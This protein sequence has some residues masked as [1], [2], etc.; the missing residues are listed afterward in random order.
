MEEKSAIKNIKRIFFFAILGIMIVGIALVM[1]TKNDSGEWEEIWEIPGEGD[2][3]RIAAGNDCFYILGNGSDPYAPPE[4]Q[5]FLCKFDL[6]G[7]NE[8]AKKLDIPMIS[9]PYWHDAI[10]T[11][12]S[13][14]FV[15][16][17]NY[18]AKYYANGSLAWS[19]NI[20]WAT[21]EAIAVNDSHVFIT[22]LTRYLGSPFLNLM[23]YDA[24]GSLDG[25]NVTL[26]GIP[27][28]VDITVSQSAIFIAGNTYND[29]IIV[30]FAANG[31]YMWNTT[32]GKAFGDFSSC[33]AV[34]DSSIY[35]TGSI[36]TGTSTG[37]YFLARFDTSGN[38][39]WNTTQSSLPYYSISI[40]D[41]MPV[42]ETYH[43]NFLCFLQYNEA[44][45]VV[46]TK[47][48]Q[49][50]GS[51][52]IKGFVCSSS[53]FYL[54]GTPT[55][56]T[57][58]APYQ[59]WIARLGLAS[60]ISP[61]GFGVNQ[62]VLS[63]IIS[64]SCIA[65][66]AL[67]FVIITAREK[68][69]VGTA[70]SR[71]DSNPKKFGAVSIA[72][73]IATIAGAAISI[74]LYF[75]GAVSPALG[76]VSLFSVESLIFLILLSVG[77]IISSAIVYCES[78]NEYRKFK[79]RFTVGMIG[80]GLVWLAICYKIQSDPGSLMIIGQGTAD[81]GLDIFV[82]ISFGVLIIAPICSILLESTY[83][84]KKKMMFVNG[85]LVRGLSGS[86][87]KKGATVATLVTR[88]FEVAGDSFK[89]N[90]IVRNPYESIISKV[91]VQL[92]LPPTL[93]LDSKSSSESA[94]FDVIKPG[95]TA[96]AT[97]YFYCIACSDD[98][99]NASIGFFDPEG[100]WNMVSMEPFQIKSCKYLRPRPIT[101]QEF[102]AI[103]NKEERKE[104][105]I[106]I[107]AGET[108]ESVLAMIKQ[109]L[110]MTTVS[111]T[112]D[113]LD[114]FGE[115]K[116][117]IGIG[118]SLV[119]KELRGVRTLITTV[120][121]KSQQVQM[122]VLSDII[123]AVRDVKAGTG[124][125]KATTKEILEKTAELLNGQ[126]NLHNSLAEKLEQ[127]GKQITTLNSRAVDMEMGG[128]ISNAEGLQKQVEVLRT[129]MKDLVGKVD[130]N[131]AEMAKSIEKALQKQDITVDYLK[132]KLGSDWEKI[133]DAW[134]EYK[135]GKRSLSSLLSGAFKE[136]GR[137][138]FERFVSSIS[139]GLV[140]L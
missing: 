78:V 46:W 36:G 93:K 91:M 38:E 4:D 39:I 69:R 10:A 83:F 3:Y 61:S 17:D 59:I 58:G 132:D 66:M 118:L 14:V 92:V 117:G 8:W 120:F 37:S 24:A 87:R 104:I 70:S 129:E 68:P 56:Y 29:A 95:T 42:V 124:E 121:G 33:I 30:K 107:K 62:I 67:S 96:M 43:G 137:R 45:Q 64:G 76:S 82:L 111:A 103:K 51:S 53:W 139:G 49:Y 126:M 81:W 73:K 88:D 7:T 52:Q 77:L 133:K 108:N 128:D 84:I 79:N 48:L 80:D 50:W 75:L 119:M 110:T 27:E 122:G 1:T 12:G 136:L 127:I 100:K 6:N 138:A 55:R 5:M 89:F 65:G 34:T 101:R 21:I 115:T 47:S 106:P 22:G 105:T 63:I 2:A 86:L 11:N 54:L 35:L 44:G 98:M 123:E 140:K 28:V 109:R 26:G 60:N 13:D 32:F 113:Q 114:L 23:R 94:E 85:V 40:V 16:K 131:M 19:Q 71:F 25:I 112:G 20:T 135:A 97:F 116:E 9:E 72:C 130:V 74:I 18:F 102:E 134:T 31:S 90:I 125:I 15:G 41:S 57:S 99:I